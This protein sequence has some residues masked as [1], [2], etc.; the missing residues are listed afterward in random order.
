M[1]SYDDDDE[2]FDFDYEYDD[3]C[4]DKDEMSFSLDNKNKIKVNNLFEQY[5]EFIE[6]VLTSGDEIDINDTYIIFKIKNHFL[7]PDIKLSFVSSSPQV[8]LLKGEGNYYL[9]IL[10]ERID[11]D[12]ELFLDIDNSD[13]KK[14]EE[15]ILGKISHFNPKE[16]DARDESEKLYGNISNEQKIKIYYDRIKSFCS[17]KNGL[18]KIYYIVKSAI[19]NISSCCMC[20]GQRLMV[21]NGPWVCDNKWC[22]YRVCF[23]MSYLFDD[24]SLLY[25]EN[26]EYVTELI[27]ASITHK[28]AHKLLKP[29]PEDFPSWDELI[30]QLTNIKN[31]K[32]LLWWMIINMHS[33]V[34]PVETCPIEVNFNRKD[35]SLLQVLTA[36]CSR[37][38][39]F[40]EEKEKKGS[41]YFFHGSAKAN[42]YSILKFGL[43]NMSSKAGLMIH[44][45]AYG[46]GIY[47]SKQFVT[48]DGY[49][50]DG[51]VGIIEVIKNEAKEKIKS[52]HTLLNDKMVRL[53]YII[54]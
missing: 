45:A 18:K 13:K 3:G 17:L 26:V 11:K 34:V 49:K 40:Q 33:R 1:E 32:K 27:L 48:A 6:E 30:P 5:S 4:D 38:H 7:L 15:R 41:E 37:E 2:D 25:P 9:N 51:Y 20:C 10:K 19:L 16:S 44:G 39:F 46:E 52:I 50:R 43:I 53:R 24:F 14:M 23:S 8:L 35:K 21:D 31:N 12:I 28:M 22:Q 36:H 54:L 29:Y 47:M 42:W